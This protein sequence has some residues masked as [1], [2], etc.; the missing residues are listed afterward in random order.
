[1]R[2][3]RI[4][5]CA[6]LLGLAPLTS[7]WAQQADPLQEANQLFRQG[8]LDRAM[9]RVNGYLATRPK[10]A[11]GRFL[12]GLILTEQNKPNEAIKVFTELSQDYPELPEP[13]NNLAVLYAS[14]GAYDKARNS[15]EMAI[16]THPSY[17]TAHENLGDI[18]AK[19]ASQAYD[20]AL[21]LDRSNQ[22]AQSKLNLIKDLFS[23]GARPPT[24][25]AAAKPESPPV[26]APKPAA[27]PPVQPV[28]PPAAK[29]TPAPP[30][31]AAEAPA[32]AASKA[33]PPEKKTAAAPA[34]NPDEVLRSVNAWARAWETNDVPGYL[35]HYASDFQTPKG[36]SR[37]A[38]EAE[39]KARIAKPRK[40]EVEVI[41]PKV[42]FDEKNRAIVTFKQSYRSG[43]LNV[44]SSK[45]LVMVKDGDKW[46][47]QQ[48][49]SGS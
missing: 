34:P 27:A 29:A 42:M 33:P 20:K 40:I 26:A 48:E 7:V 44:S 16:R 19:M 5:L 18:Y 38:W 8:Q 30:A 15:L 43:S 9:E 1:M 32:A 49:R 13:Y 6:L 28:P 10:D 21:Q 11:R 39:R 17:A 31:P 23:Q 41:A 25:V 3:P 14:Q 37:S 36:M 2:F 47:I 35:A 12:K 4:V 22:A 45:T 24:K 46:L